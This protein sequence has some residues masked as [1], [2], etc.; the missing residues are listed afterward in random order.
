MNKPAREHTLLDA[1]IGAI[2][3]EA[4]L[5]IDVIDYEVRKDDRRIIDAIVQI[6]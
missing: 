4:G 3:R 5:R 6:H 2:R 1:A